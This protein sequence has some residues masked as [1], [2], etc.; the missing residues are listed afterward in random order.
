MLKNAGIYYIGDLIIRT[1]QELLAIP[2]FTEDCLTDIKERLTARGLSLETRLEHWPPA[3]WS[4][5]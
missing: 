4:R 1:E 2:G 5:Q 3:G